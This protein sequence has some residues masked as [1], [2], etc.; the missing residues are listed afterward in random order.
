[1]QLL[2]LRIK[3][4]GRGIISP[5]EDIMQREASREET[6]KKLK[7]RSESERRTKPQGR[8]THLNV[9]PQKQLSGEVLSKKPEQL[10]QRRNQKVA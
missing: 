10:F 4:K 5:G 2:L 1:M 6:M 3:I 7:I 8:R 9:E